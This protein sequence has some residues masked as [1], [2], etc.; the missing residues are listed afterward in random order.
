VFKKSWSIPAKNYVFNNILDGE[1]ISIQISGADEAHI[2][3]KEFSRQR[4][5]ISSEKTK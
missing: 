3:L 5:A 4:I 1:M 2:S